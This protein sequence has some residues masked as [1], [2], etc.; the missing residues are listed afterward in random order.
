MEP[1]DGIEMD[2]DWRLLVTSV[3]GS[4]EKKKGAEK[5]W[6]INGWLVVEPTP[7]KNMKVNWDEYFQY[8]EKE[9]MFQT[10]NQMGKKKIIQQQLEG[11]T[12]YTRNSKRLHKC[13]KSPFY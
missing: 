5:W 10:T 8:M 13:T 2:P 1:K 4:R 9:N 6:K 12:R 11:Y 3:W 7:L